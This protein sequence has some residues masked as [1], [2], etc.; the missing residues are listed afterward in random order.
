MEGKDISS[1]EALQDEL[2]E[3]RSAWPDGASPFLFRGQS[4]SEWP[5]TTTL[6]R[7]G[8][9]EGM[10]FETYYRLILRTRPALET[11]TGTRW[12][13]SSIGEVREVTPLPTQIVETPT[14]HHTKPP[15]FL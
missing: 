6:E 2:R 13:L 12:D 7:Q 3:L 15:I 10:S 9:C 8:G 1:W 4:N 11:F 14:P 5:L